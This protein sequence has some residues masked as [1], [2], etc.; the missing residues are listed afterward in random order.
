[1]T[2]MWSSMSDKSSEGVF[3]EDDD[4]S[5]DLTLFPHDGVPS[6]ALVDFLFPLSGSVRPNSFWIEFEREPIRALRRGVRTV[7][8]M[9]ED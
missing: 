2:K 8:L 5:L 7:S 1:M 9:M 4:P 6:N 3:S